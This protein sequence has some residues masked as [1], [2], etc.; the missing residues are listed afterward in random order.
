[1]S[2]HGPTWNKPLPPHL[3]PEGI[4]DQVSAAVWRGDFDDL[5]GRGK[6]LQ[7]LN[8]DPLWW[9]KDKLKREQASVLP[10]ALELRKDVEAALAEMRAVKSETRARDILGDI[11]EK[12]RKT[13]A[14]ITSGPPSNLVPFDV[15]PLI[16]RWRR[17]EL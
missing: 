1:M 10:A 2:N 13:N 16:E 14:T 3:R 8:D 17:G 4:E 6:P 12:I 7:G 9:V 5:P 15:E 11:N